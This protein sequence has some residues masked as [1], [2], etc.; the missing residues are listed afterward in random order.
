[1]IDPR[2]REAEAK[3]R[4]IQKREAESLRLHGAEQI[5][6]LE[7]LYHAQWAMMARF[8]RNGIPEEKWRH[9]E[10]CGE[11]VCPHT[12][13]SG[14]CW[15]GERAETNRLLVQAAN[16]LQA[17]NKRLFFVTVIDPWYSCSTGSLSQLSLSAATLGIKRRFRNAS[18]LFS[19]DIAFGFAE[20][21]MMEWY[22]GVR[23][24]VMHFHIVLA[25]NAPQD[26]VRE[27]F[28][29]L[30]KPPVQF[31]AGRKKW[32]PVVVKPVT[33]LHNVLA[34]S[35]KRKVEFV[36]PAGANRRGKAKAT[37][38]ATSAELCEYDAWLLNQRLTHRLFFR[39]LR[40]V[41]GNLIPFKS[42][43]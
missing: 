15:F 31:L 26:A 23:R 37:G 33:S 3:A 7:E 43:R 36:P 18:H 6:T 14:A 35:A 10:A 40:R 5:R 22:R 42:A 32:R 34:Y 8:A 4:Y 9:L 12:V 25:T 1:M 21:A 39:G 11:G 30:R 38:Q 20:V 28:R 16:L 17:S 13:C 27:A 29:P 2:K 24:W 19:T 41:H